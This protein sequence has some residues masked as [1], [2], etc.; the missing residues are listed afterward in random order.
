MRT[1]LKNIL[2]ILGIY[3]GSILLAIILSPLGGLIHRLFWE[4][5]GCWF[6]GPCDTEANTEGFIYFYIFLL[7]ISAFSL[8]KQKAAWTVFVIGSV[9]FWAG[10]IL[11]IITE[12][13][14]LIREEYV[15][16]LVIMLI[17]FAIGYAIAFGVRKLKNR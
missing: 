11:M 13:L 17:S 14:K 6:W 10:Y 15:G 4:S 16:S 12:D 9:L 2:T 8:L 7:A 1:K 5:Q 3:V